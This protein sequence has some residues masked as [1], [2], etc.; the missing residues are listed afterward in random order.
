MLFG[1][2][3]SYSAGMLS[4]LRV[5]NLA[6]VENVRLDLGPG[7]NV[8]TGETGAGKSVLMGAL[9]L[10]LGERADKSLVR[11]GE[12]ACG[13]E[14]L[15]ELS[16]TS[17]L[18][19]VLEEAGLPPCEDGQLILRRIVRVS[20]AGQNL[21]N[22]SP[23]TL[24]VLKR[25]G[26]LLVDMHGPHDHQSL[27]HPDVQT[28]ILDAFGRL[29][30]ERLAYEEIYRQRLDL[31]N[32]REELANLDG[33]VETQLDLLSYRVK[34]IEEAGLKEGEEDEIRQE[35]LV[36]GSA[37]RI[38]E[39][40]GNLQQLLLEGEDPLF[41]RLASAQPA[42]EELARLLPEA[43]DWHAEVSEVAGRLREV[44]LSMAQ[45][46]ERVEADPSR[47]DWLDQRL[48][49][50]QKMKRKYGGS[51]EE[52]LAVLER[53]RQRLDD[54]QTRGE[55]LAEVEK[56][57]AEADAALD[58][59]GKALRRKRTKVVQKLAGVV[60]AELQAL[61]FPDGAFLVELQP[62]E[63]G[64]RGMDAVEFGFA[65]NVGEPSR[66]LHAIASSG[67]ISRVMLATKAVLAAHDRIPLLVFDEIDANV[68]GEMGHA[69]GQKM[70]EVAAHHQVLCI[71]HLPQ[72]A[73]CGRNH[74]AVRK[75]VEDGRTYTR[76]YSL[77]LDARIDEIARMLGGTDHNDVTREHA[78]ALL[79]E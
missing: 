77:D 68:G 12:D 8:I 60:T 44:G 34:E 52:I 62:A 55:R 17:D 38:L 73:A 33:D 26:D 57:L 2:L 67:E 41:D 1:A 18:D 72:V 59:A 22:D 3:D 24:Q 79:G 66:P 61:G 75:D 32:R 20:G 9:G 13:A 70:A 16:D 6:L 28:D 69:V 58:K 27:L 74:L 10:L 19:A 51:V 25:L 36:A 37:Q 29:A 14:A 45:A 21:V 30:K 11:A 46:A 5:K 47:L 65:P 48:A 23:V 15:F 49:T 64:P 71:T 76:V 53:D 39:L 63:P 54:L 43:E 35:H 78:K 4:T 7:L 42:L 31:W 40:A 56:A 50:Y